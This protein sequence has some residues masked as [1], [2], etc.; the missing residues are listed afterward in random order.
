MRY[1]VFITALILLFCGSILNAEPVS[2]EEKDPPLKINSSVRYMPSRRA[3]A[4]SGKIGITEAL[5]E[6]SY[7]FKAFDKLPVEVSLG[8]QYIGINNTTGVE[9]PSHLTGLEAGIET[10]LPFFKFDKTY[11]RLGIS[12]AF[13][14]DD[15][16]VSS[17]SFRIPSHTF[18]IHQPNSKLT[19]IAGVAVYPDFERSVLPV[20]GFIYKP[21][22][23]LTFNITPKEPNINYIL[24][25]RV[26]LFAEGGGSLNCEFEVTKDDLK[27]VVLR[28]N[29][30][31]LGAGVKYKFNKFIQSSVS[32]GGLFNRYFKYRDSLGKVNIKDGLYTEFR[33]DFAI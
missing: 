7:E 3:D 4:M 9:L 33:L 20:L 17:S 16:N 2:G 12:P 25:D 21:N 14:S 23:K 13:Y 32:A 5:S 26:T 29:Q 31:R 22:P 10:T 11:L 28:Y 1:A 8:T 24:N 15:W 27:N 6:Y 30:L 19:L 18:I